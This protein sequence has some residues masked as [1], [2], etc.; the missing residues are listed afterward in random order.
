MKPSPPASIQESRSPYAKKKIS[1][2]VTRGRS[3][4]RHLEVVR[5]LVDQRRKQK[6]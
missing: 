4:R 1:L 5:H 3:Y 2:R 6:G